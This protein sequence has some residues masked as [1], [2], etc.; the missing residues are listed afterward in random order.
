VVS[1][2]HAPS[3]A[4]V[5]RGFQRGYTPSAN[6]ACAVR[7]SLRGH[8]PTETAHARYASKVSNSKTPGTVRRGAGPHNATVRVTA[9]ATTMLTKRARRHVVPSGERVTFDITLRA[10]T[11][12][13]QDASLCDLLSPGM[14]VVS[15]PGARFRNGRPC[16]CWAYVAK[17][18]VKRVRL[19]A[20]VA[21]GLTARELTNRVTA[22]ADNVRTPH[23]IRP[24]PN[25]AGTATRSHRLA[26]SRRRI[27]KPRTQ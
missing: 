27:V 3:T 25:P 20:R 4:P 2:P 21:S 13:I 6:P 15:A 19:T 12:A 26:S 17:H 10:N 5:I 23:R 11:R 22:Q 14:S 24:G 16:W 18:E 9:P 8:A 7:P 1:G